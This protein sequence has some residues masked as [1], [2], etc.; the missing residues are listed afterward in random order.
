MPATYVE[1]DSEAQTLLITLYDE[2]IQTE[3]ILSYTIY[4]D[5]PV[6]CRNTYIKNWG[7]QK[8]V[9]NQIMS[10]S[11]DLPDYNYEM[12]ELT[13]AWSRERNVKNRKLEHGSNQFIHFG[14]VQVIILI[15]LLL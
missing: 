3:L 7:K 2:V 11:L 14:A 13:G 6:I 1:N 5:L 9:L 12:I 15:P 4:E 10:M 8:L